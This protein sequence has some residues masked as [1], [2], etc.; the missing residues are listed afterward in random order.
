MAVIQLKV[1]PKALLSCLPLISNHHLLAQSQNSRSF[2]MSLHQYDGAH[3]RGME[4]LQFLITRLQ[5]NMPSV[6]GH[7]CSRRQGS[8]AHP[9]SHWGIHPH[10]SGQHKAPDSL[11]CLLLSVQR[12]APIFSLGAPSQGQRTS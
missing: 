2:W 10:H 11:S 7:S 4:F 1:L 9:P 12:T 5:S 8:S 6:A 3:L